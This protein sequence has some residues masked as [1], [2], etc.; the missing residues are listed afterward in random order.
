[1]K[2]VIKN[3]ELLR[4]KNANQTIQGEAAERLKKIMEEATKMKKEVEDKLGKIQGGVTT[5]SF[6]HW[7]SVR[8]S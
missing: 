4:Q 2:D 5:I 7:C 8:V 1:M 6:D 3:F